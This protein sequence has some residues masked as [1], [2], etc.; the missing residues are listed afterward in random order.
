MFEINNDLKKINYKSWHN[1]FHLIISCIL[2]II[3]NL[4][5]LNISSSAF[6]VYTIGLVWEI[7]DGF[8]PWYYDFSY[9]RRKW[10]L[11]NFLIKNILYSNKFSLQDILIWNMIGTLIGYVV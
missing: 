2:V 11:I 5:G 10:P 1:W 8:K 4:F 6:I 9:D 7:G 3:F